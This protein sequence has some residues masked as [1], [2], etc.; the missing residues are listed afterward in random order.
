MQNFRNRLQLKDFRLIRAIYETGQLALAAERLSMTQPAASRMLAG[1]E[2]VAGIALFTRHPKGMIPTPV[3][4]VLAHNAA[5]ILNDIDRALT[6]VVAVGK[7]RSGSVRVGAVT[8]GAVG[9]VVPA[10]QQLK[11]RA[12]GADIYVDVAPSGTLMER[13]INGEYDFVLSRVPVG[14]DARQFHVQ[15]GRIEVIKFLVREG[16]PLAGKK[17]LRLSELAN[18]EWV[19]QAPHTPMRLAIEDALIDEGLSP[20]AETVNTTSLLVTIA[21]LTTSDA[22]APIT[23]EVTDLLGHSKFGGKV[24]ALDVVNDIVVNPYHLISRRNHTMGPLAARLRELVLAD[25]SEESAVYPETTSER[26][27]PP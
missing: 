1:I 26:A 7:G 8:G 6:D 18:Y 27:S 15:C 24:E 14:V 21:Y 23:M 4:E 13:L 25:M 10:I 17:K 3:G 20:P 2:K 19:I 5:A 22:I 16:H 9:I 11:A 12:K